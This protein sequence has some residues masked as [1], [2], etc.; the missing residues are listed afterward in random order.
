MSEL[1][2]GLVGATGTDLSEIRIFLQ[3]ALQEVGYTTELIK[4]STLLYEQEPGQSEADRL[5]ESMDAGDEVRALATNA[6]AVLG[7]QQVRQ[8][9]VQK[10]DGIDEETAKRTPLSKTAY[11]F[12]SLKHP[13]EVKLLRKCYGD[14]FH[15]ISV[16]SDEITREQK[17]KKRLAS[18]D[19][20]LSPKQRSDMASKLMERDISDQKNEL[21]QQVRKT[22][23]LADLF[24]NLD[25]ESNCEKAI[26]R[27]VRL[28]FGDVFKTP[29]KEEFGMFYA[30]AAAVRSA[31]LGRQVGAAIVNDQAELISTGS[32]EVPKAGGGQY[33]SDDEIDHRDF[34]K[35]K[36]INDER[37]KKLVQDLLQRLAS[38]N[39]LSEEANIDTL[40]TSFF[41]GAPPGYIEGAEVFN[42]IGY[43]R[44]VHGETAALLEAARRGV[45]VKEAIV[46][47]TTFPCHECARHIVCAGI[48]E[49]VYIEPY[50]KSLALEQY[51]DSIMVESRPVNERRLKQKLAKVRFRPFVGVAPR[52]YL[53]LFSVDK[54]ERKNKDGTVKKWDKEKAQLRHFERSIGYITD[55]IDY[56]AGLEALHAQQEQQD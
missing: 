43:Y 34:T 10:Q 18:S 7:I 4:L 39:L 47:V 44:A 23:P 16:F 19:A 6:V 37:Q 49:V 11:I 45:S 5:K 14:S 38:A 22:F 8:I 53:Q 55:E 25:D 15:L 31:D 26:Q 35:E 56:I 36:D 33:W 27:Y 29:S 2:V 21:G 32:N 12:H 1:F 9:R 46:Y 17:L 30:Q 48:R 50:P 52:K 40:V 42:V 54:G 51:P 41:S 13:D 3:D 20:S 28:L 24:V